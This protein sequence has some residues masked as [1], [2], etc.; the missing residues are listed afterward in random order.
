MG[1][2]L[3]VRTFA[4]GAISM[5]SPT[6]VP[7]VLRLAIPA[8][9]WAEVGCCGR[10]LPGEHVGHA[11]ELDLREAAAQIARVKGHV[12]GVECDPALNHRGNIFGR[13]EVDGVVSAAENSRFAVFENWS[14]D[15]LGPQLHVGVWMHDDPIEL[16]GSKRFFGAILH[17]PEL[18][19]VVGRG[20]V[21]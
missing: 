5:V 9:A 4:F 1:V 13:V 20:A 2:D 12:D 15:N 16:A 18:H 3:N 19:C 11:S 8:V 7:K 10:S 14:S 21:Y 6:F 17:P